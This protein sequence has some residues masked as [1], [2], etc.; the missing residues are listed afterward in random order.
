V[1]FNDVPALLARTRWVDELSQALRA[2]RFA[3]IE[4][5]KQLFGASVL[6]S[7]RK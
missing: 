3:N 7:A 5:E 6:V 2:H 4:I 1:A